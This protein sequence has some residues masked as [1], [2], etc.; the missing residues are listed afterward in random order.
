MLQTNGSDKWR[1]R[2]EGIL[3]GTNLFFSPDVKDV[4]YEVA[5]EGPKTCNTDNKSFKAYLSR[6]MAATTKLAPFTFDLIMPKLRASAAAAALQCSGGTDGK[7]CGLRWTEGA[8]WD[9]ST[10]V[11]EQMSA[12][13]VFQSILITKAEAPVTN[14]TGGTSKGDPSAGT[15]GTSGQPGLV[16]NA[17][18]KKDKVGA[19]IL[20]TLV[21]MG[22]IGGSWWIVA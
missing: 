18:T 16:P 6:W 5:C 7:T 19:G 4:M 22:V 12:M 14:S 9:G 2:V 17:V 8:K 10:G 21:L 20:T 13:E 3:N 15:G 11:G 1:Q